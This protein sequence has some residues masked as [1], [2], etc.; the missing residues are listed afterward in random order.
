MREVSGGFYGVIVCDTEEFDVVL[1]T[2]SVIRET[3]EEAMKD[4]ES[5][6]KYVEREFPDCHTRPDTQEA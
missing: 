3:R 2:Y 5:M 6:M 4:A 1:Y